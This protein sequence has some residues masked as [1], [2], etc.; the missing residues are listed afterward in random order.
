LVIL[1]VFVVESS[2]FA[3]RLARRNLLRREQRQLATPPPV[4]PTRI[5]P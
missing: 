5:H 4:M 1:V 3:F 2:Q